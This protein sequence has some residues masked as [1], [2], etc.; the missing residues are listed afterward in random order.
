L[1]GTKQ[2][3]YYTEQTRKSTQAL[4]IQIPLFSACRR[5]G[6]RAQQDRV[7]QRSAQK[8]WAFP[9]IEAG[10][11]FAHTAQ[12]LATRPV[13]APLPNASEAI[14]SILYR[15]SLRGGTTWQSPNYRAAI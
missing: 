6:G 12:A 14:E 7:S 5:E 4:Q 3:L 15:A 8:L 9:L 11:L 13:S 10:G 1:R 2:S